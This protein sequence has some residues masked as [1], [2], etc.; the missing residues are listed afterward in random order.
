MTAVILTLIAYLDVQ[1]VQISVMM[2]TN[3]LNSV[4]Q[5]FASGDAATARIGAVMAEAVSSKID[6]EK[7]L[8]TTLLDGQDGL[9]ELKG[10][11]FKRDA[12]DK[13]AMADLSTEEE[14]HAPEG[15]DLDRDGLADEDE[16]EDELDPDAAFDTSRCAM[17]SASLIS[18]HWI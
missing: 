15:E 6:K 1:D 18:S 11:V 16:D 9:V 13:D 10:L 5:Y 2:E 7:P 8:N 17:V 12:L 4:S 14:K 3:L